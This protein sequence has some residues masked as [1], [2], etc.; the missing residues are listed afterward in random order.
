M[1]IAVLFVLLT[2]AAGAQQQPLLEVTSKLGTKFFSLPDE[3][4]AIAAARTNLAADPKNPDL[5]LKLEQAQVS[6]WQDREAVET[7]TRILTITPDSADILTE[8]GHRELPLREFARS[9]ADL[10]RS[11]SLNPKKMGTFYHLGL[12]HYFLGAF[13][14]AGVAFR[15][16]VDLAPDTDERINSTNWLYASLRRAGQ[17]KE[18]A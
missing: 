13:Q 15:Q 3:K 8:R 1:K 16:S 12:A 4:G 2:L 9:R 7:C 18:A 10:T 5:L 6:V 17:D 14:E 11:A